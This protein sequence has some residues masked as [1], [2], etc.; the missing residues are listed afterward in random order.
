MLPLTVAKADSC[1]CLQ[2]LTVG[3][4]QIIKRISIHWTVL[5]EGFWPNLLYIGS[6]RAEEKYDLALEND[7]SE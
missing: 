3:D 5:Q 7:I 1:Y 6:S 4:K 2:G